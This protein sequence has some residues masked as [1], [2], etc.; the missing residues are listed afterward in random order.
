MPEETKKLNLYFTEG[1]WKELRQR[2]IVERSSASQIVTRLLEYFL[3]QPST[4]LA[5][6]P[7]VHNK[8]R[9]PAASPEVGMGRTLRIPRRVYDE[10]E[11]RIA[12]KVSLS[13]LCEHLVRLYL[14][15]AQPQAS[16]PKAA[17]PGAFDFQLGDN[18]FIID[19]KTGKIKQG[20]QEE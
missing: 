5:P 3:Q 1:V 19:L 15:P 11:R 9:I 10:V 12:G 20:D 2:A 17:P 4:E 6:P 14:Q 7:G 8:P 18:P 13:N 16:P